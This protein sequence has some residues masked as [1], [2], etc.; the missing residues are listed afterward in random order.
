MEILFNLVYEPYNLLLAWQ[1]VWQG[2]TWAERRRGAGVDGVTL[3]D[4]EPERDARLQALGAALRE[5]S[6]RPEPLLYF[7]IPR[8]ESG[9]TRRIGIATV[10]DRV[11]QRAV[12]N[13]LEPLLEAHFL[14]CSHGYRPNRSVFTAVAHILWHQARGL[15]WVLDADISA[16][17]DTVVHARLLA[18]LDGLQDVRLSALI[19][20]W[21]E[22]GAS[23][24]GRGLAQG[25][26]ISPLLAN[27]Y[28]HPF[29]VALIEAGWALVRYADDFVILCADAAAARVALVDAADALAALELDLNGEKTTIVPF[30]A[31]FEF[32]GA[33]FEL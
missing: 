20:A 11:A 4:W 21:L 16:Y 18:Q 9:E 15:N 22:V 23:A 19:T 32:L 27:L 33:R 13:V 25:A 24:P 5:G 1:K 2:R 8:G 31:D 10:T 7:E 3:A 26:V 17:F 29:D 14:S 30:G 12:Q 28:L 6:Y